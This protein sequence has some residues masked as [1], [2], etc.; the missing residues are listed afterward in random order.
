MNGR[1]YDP[2][3]GR[4]LSADLVVQ[5]PGNLQSYNRYSYV[6]NNPLRFVDPS[7]FQVAEAVVIDAA[8]S[9]A[10]GVS[11]VSAFESG[12]NFNY[13]L[14]CVLQNVVYNLEDRAA[15]LKQRFTGTP[16]TTPAA[17]DKGKIE[18]TQKNNMSAPATQL[19]NST[20]APAPKAPDTQEGLTQT[21]PAD[22]V[23]TES[24]KVDNSSTTPNTTASPAPAADVPL[25]T[26]MTHGNS[27]SSEKGQQGYV[28]LDTHNNNAVVK[29]GISGQTPNKDGSSPR[30][31]LQANKWNGVEKTPGRYVPKVVFEVA[32]GPGARAAAKEAEQQVS[33]QNRE[34]LDPTKHKLP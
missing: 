8:M 12:G 1:I 4:M 14:A 2:L 26:E 17:G 15:V 27:S 28:I 19:P 9:S 13:N 32:P 6:Q 20:A 25:Q 18:N 29:N 3:L 22:V 30:A 23:H 31:N 11:A 5:F 16:V 34:T 24:I 7:G 33:E 21:A 10:G